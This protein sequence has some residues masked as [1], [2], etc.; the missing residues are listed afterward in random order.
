MRP[1]ATLMGL[2]IVAALACVPAAAQT[3][4]LNLDWRHIQAIPF[5]EKMDDLLCGQ[6]Q[7]RLEQLAASLKFGGYLPVKYVREQSYPSGTYTFTLWRNAK[8]QELEVAHGNGGTCVYQ[9]LPQTPTAVV[10]VT[11]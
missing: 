5:T 7:H 9:L 3:F 10:S 8:K 11:Q 4:T 1:V 2:G 6:G